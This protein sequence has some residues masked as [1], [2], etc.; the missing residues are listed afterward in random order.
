MNIT[1]EKVNELNEL[2]DDVV[3]LFCDEH[4]VSGQTAW[5]CVEVLAICK[6]LELAGVLTSEPSEENAL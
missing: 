2:L 4:M 3:A 5:T 1:Q 6:T